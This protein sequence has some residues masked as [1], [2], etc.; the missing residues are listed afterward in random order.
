MPRADPK[1]YFSTKSFEQVADPKVVE[2]WRREQFEQRTP[3]WFEA[4]MKGISASDCALALTMN[5]AACDYY[6][7][8]FGLHD[9]FKKNP[10]KCANHYSTNGKKEIIL[11]KCKRTDTSSSFSNPFMLWGQKYEPIVQT[12]YSQMR[13]EDVLE[14]GLLFHPTVPFLMASPDGIT[15][16]GTMLEIK[17]PTKRPVGPVPPLHYFHQMMMQ[18]ECCG[19]AE[20][21]FFDCSFIEYLFDD[22]W[23]SDAQRWWNS[24]E[25]GRHHIFGIL[26][27]NGSGVYTYAPP[28]VFSP[29]DFLAWANSE[30]ERALV[31]DEIELER[32][33]YKLEKYEL[34][35]IKYTPE[36]LTLN[37]PAFSE[38]WEKITYYRSPE[39]EA[40]FIA[41]ENDT[42]SA[43]KAAADAKQTKL[44][45]F[46][47]ADTGKEEPSASTLTI[48]MN[49][50]DIVVSKETPAKRG[51][52]AV[53]PFVDVCLC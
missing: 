25:G 8:S 42:P 2:L 5:D 12:I 21:D 39:G 51:R 15:T 38:I 10:K 45:Q 24:S 46:F 40:D 20:C 23:L 13:N 49:L 36:F 6:I 37:L 27:S 48:N 41:F 35:R 18:L 31:E 29:S 30:I 28:T 32:V 52:K 47:S 22:E 34:V 9:T 50:G 17:C 44:D 43:R 16:S 1:L 7:E 19:L 4:R 3:E 14:Y 53:P 26:L 11:K 33:Y